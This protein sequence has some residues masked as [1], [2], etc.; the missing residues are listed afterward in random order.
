VAATPQ[1]RAGV[2]AAAAGVAAPAALVVFVTLVDG[3]DDPVRGLVGLVVVLVDEAL[4]DGLVPQAAARS[5]SPRQSAA[6]SPRGA[7]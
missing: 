5:G 7:A 2:G 4:V 6:I 3:A 1:G